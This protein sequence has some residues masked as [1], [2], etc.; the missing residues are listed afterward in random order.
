MSIPENNQIDSGIANKESK[1]DEEDIPTLSQGVS[2][3]KIESQEKT[4]SNIF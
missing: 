1:S 2:V 4:V 3:D